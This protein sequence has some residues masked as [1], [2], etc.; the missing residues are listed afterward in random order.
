MSQYSIRNIFLPIFTHFMLF[1]T[2]V[3]FAAANLKPFIHH[4]LLIDRTPQNDH[5]HWTLRQIITSHT[6]AL[7][8]VCHFYLLYL[9]LLHE[10]FSIKNTMHLPLAS[11]I[12]MI[13]YSTTSSYNPSNRVFNDSI[14]NSTPQTCAWTWSINLADTLSNSSHVFVD[15]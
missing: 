12:D 1:R 9:L 6:L 8:V 4:T 15:Q 14:H 3:F 2:W 7:A 13:W 5:R 10:H 11:F